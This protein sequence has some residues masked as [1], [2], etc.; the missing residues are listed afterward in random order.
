MIARAWFFVAGVLVG[1]GAVAFFVMRYYDVRLVPTRPVPVVAPASN[2]PSA[3]V[4]VPPRAA[5]PTPLAP[6]PTPAPAPSSPPLASTPAANASASTAT[7]TA[8]LIPVEGV[9]ASELVDTFNQT[10]G[11]TRIHEALDIMAP[12]GREVVAVADG[13]VVKLFNSQQGG[14]TVY[15]FD[16]TERY[17]YYY[18]H[19]D[20][21][22]AGLMEGKLIKRGELIGYVGSTG[23]ASPD[24]PH[25]H[26][27]I[28]ELGPEKRW[29]EGRPINPYPLLR[30][31]A[32]PN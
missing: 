12:R 27:A 2:P 28:F 30:G 22:A 26:F 32:V 16:P 10:R 21:Y 14:L 9:Q 7:A 13:K 24:A 19:L 15:Q 4:V 3:S 20:R 29:W 6:A 17:A 5:S 31:S 23:N 11:G 1:A 8:L 25:L 18:A